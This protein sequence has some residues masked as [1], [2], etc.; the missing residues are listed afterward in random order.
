MPRASAGLLPF[1]L[2]EDRPTVFLGRMGGPLW[3]RRPRAWT[4]IKGEHEGSEQSLAAA[5]REFFEET[6]VPAPAGPRI[7]LGEV[8]QSGGKQVTAWAVRIADVRDLEFVA[9]GSFEMEWP[10]RSGRRQVFPELDGAAW[11]GVDAARELV[12]AAQVE[13]LDRLIGAVSPLSG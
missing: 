10:P 7:P 1:V 12:V 11:H 3:T 8:R 6:G 4:I 2:T 9:S 5:E 13:F